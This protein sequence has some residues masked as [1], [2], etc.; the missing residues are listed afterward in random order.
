LNLLPF[1]AIVEEAL[2]GETVLIYNMPD[3]LTRG[4]LLVS[5]TGGAQRD[6]D[7]PGMRRARFQAV[8]R[9]REYQSGY[10]L[11]LQV[12]AALD[13]REVTPEVG[14]RIS[15]VRPLNDPIAFSRSKGGFIE[16]SINFE[17]IYMEQ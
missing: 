7:I 11:G 10:N 6:L 14:F 15:L 13:K 12:A 5:N 17:T 2:P 16:F 9:E 8:I 3:T 1:K 4:I